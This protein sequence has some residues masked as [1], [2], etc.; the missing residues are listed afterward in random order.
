MKVRYGVHWSVS[1]AI[2]L[3][4]SILA[5]ICVMISLNPAVIATA[6]LATLSLSFLVDGVRQSLK[7]ISWQFPVILVFAFVNCLFAQRGTTVFFEAGPFVLNLEGIAYGAFMGLMVMSALSYFT[8]LAEAISSDDVM[9]LFSGKA[10]ITS[11]ATSMS[12]GIVPKL[13]EQERELRAIDA[14]CT[15]ARTETGRSRY[16]NPAKRLTHLLV[17]SLEDSLIRADSMRARGWGFSSRRSVY[18]RKRMTA[19]EKIALILIALLGSACV[20]FAYISASCF[21]FYPEIT[22]TACMH[23]ELGSLTAPQTLWIGFSLCAAFFF[24]PHAF[25]LIEVAKWRP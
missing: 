20:F 21:Q 10:P 19:K 7:R 17:T 25:L 3:T 22:F 16:A 6:Y 4:Y 12:L 24:L 9:N 2:A 23:P 8:L 15:C 1:S 5:I 18:K 13:H 11:L 14:A